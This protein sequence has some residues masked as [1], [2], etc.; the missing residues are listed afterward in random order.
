MGRKSKLSR[1]P[2]EVKAFIEAEIASGK[3][4]LNDLIALL[5]KRF[6]G[7]E[8]PSRSGV[9]RFTQKMERRLEA[10]KAT[11]EAAKLIRA[12]AGDSEDA[13]SEALLAMVQTQ[14]IETIVSLREIDDEDI[15][16]EDRLTK[17]GRVGQNIAAMARSSIT[18]KRY[19]SETQE[20]AKAAAE[21]V[22]KIASKGGLTAEVA[23]QLRREIL[24]IAA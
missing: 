10:V 19:Q 4:T 12:H 13:R 1:L 2:P 20:R 18:L 3:H 23:A 15:D 22:D 7:A 21:T 16:H 8:L 24:G 6:P 5:Q 17:L 11:T 14:M 9:G